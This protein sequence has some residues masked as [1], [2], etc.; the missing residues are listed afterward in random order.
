MVE[1]LHQLGGGFVSCFTP[2]NFIALVVGLVAGM[3]VA[4]LPG[5]TAVMG[6]VL[7]LPFTYGMPIVPSII[8]L[9]AM[10][11]SGTYGGAFTSIL[12]RI[13]GEP[14]DV[15]LLWDGYAMAHKGQPAMAL[16]WTLIAALF[17]GLFSTAI[18][19]M[20]AHSFASFA[21]RFDS[22]EYFA[23]ILF[24]LTSVVALGGGSMVNA[25][26]SLLL[27]LAT[28]TVGS[29]GIYGAVRFT[30]GVPMLA[31]GI[32]YLT[33]MVGAYGLGEVLVR[34]EQG[35]GTK[36]PERGAKIAT[37]FPTSRQIWE[38][39]GTVARSSVLGMIL[40]L[41]PG[42][43]ATIASFVSYGVEAQYCKR[44]ALLGSGIA[45]G[46]VAPQMAS[47]AT[48]AGHMVPLLTLGIP[49]SGATAVI[50][51]A[52]LLHGVQPGPQVFISNGDLVNTIFA[53]LFLGV[54]GMCLMGY[55]A[56][57]LLI[58]VLYLPEAVTSAFVVLFCFI[59]AFA[60][61]NNITD[62]WMIVTFGVVGYLFER[63]KFPIAPMVLGCILGSEAENAFMTSMLSFQN[64]WT[65]FFTRPI[66]GSVMAMAAISLVFPLLRQ[67]YQRGNLRLKFWGK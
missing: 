64:D 35:F 36:A 67:M 39:R 32:E 54:I 37:H 21:L 34:L 8:L 58:K 60:A 66:A 62:L 11:M 65:V 18:A 47:T 1:I 41:I 14:L 53:S 52:F 61:R 50:L 33:V 40:G 30:F 9:T 55:F 12:F 59:G 10:Y 6:L 26:I 57:K 22:P 15:P 7:V 19:V 43:G 45:E 51:G 29:D 31:D 25:F 27:G 48:V 13:P 24:G 20:M 44:R 46:I 56:I 63:F 16:G 3:L 23:V 28:A 4:V 5:L 2:I 42:A 17:G 38:I 49:G